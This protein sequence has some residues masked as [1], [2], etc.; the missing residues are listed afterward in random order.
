MPGLRKYAIGWYRKVFGAPAGSNIRDEGLD[1]VL[2][3]DSAVA[4]SEAGIDSH[5][6]QIAEGPRGIVASA[7]GLALAG[8]RATAF[9][10]GP[11]IA[12]AREYARDPGTRQLTGQQ[13]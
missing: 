4:L 10:T 12:A 11:D 2:D 13:P 9:L 1:T 3:G 5:A 7:T 6:V 8:R